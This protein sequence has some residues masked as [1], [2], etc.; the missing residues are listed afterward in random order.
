MS[1]KMPVSVHILTWN[2]GATLRH[3]LES[4]KQCAEI[5]IIDGGSTDGTLSIAEE[6]GATVIPQRERNQGTPTRDFAAVRNQ[7]L[8]HTT[9]PWILS[10]DSDES[11]SPALLQEIAV[12]TATGIPCA[13]LVPRRYLLPDG[14]TVTHATT[15]PNARLYFFHREAV[16]RWEKPVHER[17]VLKAGF[18]LHHLRWATLAPLGD[19][20]DYRRKNLRYLAIEQEKD[21]GKGWWY[22]ITHRVF[23]TLRSR[24][25]A[26]VRFA[27][28]W[29]LPHTNTVRLPLQHE[30]LRFWYAWKLIV[31]TCPLSHV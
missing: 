8:E 14:R 2:S 24:A 11:A 17:P 21:R 1:E 9:Q 29:L 25:I 7:G 4:I 15:Y 22:W 13:C 27:W 12:V 5:L 31:A 6:Y 19:L 26:T 28:I 10:L 3:C 30:L 16:E 20:E 23:P 18:P